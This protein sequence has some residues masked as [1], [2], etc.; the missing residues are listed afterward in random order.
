MSKLNTHLLVTG[1]P[2]PRPAPLLRRDN[3]VS[4]AAGAEPGLVPPPGAGLGQPPG[5]GLVPPP[6][7]GLRSEP[8]L[9]IVKVKGGNVNKINSQQNKK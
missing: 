5:A 3:R 4:V 7:A 9:G 6:G 1:G 2:E 8:E